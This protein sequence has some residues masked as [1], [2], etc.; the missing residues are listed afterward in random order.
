MSEPSNTRPL[1]TV[2]AEIVASP[3]PESVDLGITADAIE[4]MAPDYPPLYALTDRAATE[5]QQRSIL[6]TQ[7]DMAVMLTGAAISVA[8]SFVA[9]EPYHQILSTAAVVAFVLMWAEK[10][11]MPRFRFSK[12]WFESRSVAETTKSLMW[13]YMM[14]APPYDGED[15]DRRFLASLRDT[16]HT[17]EITLEHAPSKIDA[18]QITPYMRLIRSLPAS[19]RKQIYL[20]LRVNDQLHYYS[21]KAVRDA[22]FGKRWRITGFIFRAATFVFAVAR[23]WLDES[24]I[25]VG[26]FVNLT[27]VVASWAQLLKYENLAKGY[28]QVS[29]SLRRLHL[30]L[31]HAQDEHAF[32]RVV[33]ETEGV[34]SHEETVWVL[35]RS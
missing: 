24:G 33:L 3:H 31:N 11:I 10:T 13:R 16:L 30:E 25:L 2:A 17:H 8:V 32:E 7:F 34:I 26:L 15:G 35:K 5:G 1:S 6:S 29:R 4:R 14:R 18:R 9:P 19:E 12:N 23:F 27:V 21:S 28:A 20:R 22:R